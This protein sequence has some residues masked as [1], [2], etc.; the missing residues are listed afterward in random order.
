MKIQTAILITVLAISAC[1][2]EISA[3]EKIEGCWKNHTR[4]SSDRTYSLGFRRAVRIH[5]IEL[6][7]EWCETVTSTK[8]RNWCSRA[9]SSGAWWKGSIE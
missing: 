3:K 2:V 5:C 6:E 4:V 7:Q 1:G 9:E 8:D